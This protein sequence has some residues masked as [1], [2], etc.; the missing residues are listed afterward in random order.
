M[1]E[2]WQVT[3]QR[4]TS[5][6]SNGQFENAYVVTFRTASGVTASVTVPKSQ[7]NADTVA[8]LITEQVAH[9]DSVSGL[10]ASQAPQSSGRQG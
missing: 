4:E 7:Y 10:T 6:L 8:K 2:Q 9:I 5:I 1:A 3:G